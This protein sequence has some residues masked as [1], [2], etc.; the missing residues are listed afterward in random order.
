MLHLVA[1]ERRARVPLLVAFVDLAHYQRFARGLSPEALADL[2]DEL[3]RRVDARVRGAGGHVVKY[4]G[5]A[6]LLVFDE[7]HVGSAVTCLLALKEEVDAWLE[8]AGV[9]SSLHVKAHFGE[10]VAG[11]FGPDDARRF[12]VLGATVNAAATLAERP[13]AITPQV[14]RKLPSDGRRAFKKHTPPV[15][16]IRVGDRHG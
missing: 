7:D 13:F 9:G 15:S 1:S 11:P 16:Y 12:D 14:F 6:A 3:Y 2:L 8:D 4:I 10:C 5:D